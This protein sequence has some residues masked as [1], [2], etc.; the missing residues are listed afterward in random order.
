MKGFFGAH[1]RHWMQLFPAKQFVVIDSEKYFSD[2]G[3]VEAQV[4]KFLRGEDDQGLSGASLRVR[5]RSLLQDK[6]CW[7]NCETKKR[8]YA[9]DVDDKLESELRALYYPDALLLEDSRKYVRWVN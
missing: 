2:A 4:L 7:H 6:T 9:Q 8:S 3:T 1:L 5:R